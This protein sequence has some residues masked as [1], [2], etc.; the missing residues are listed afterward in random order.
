MLYWLKSGQAKTVEEL[1]TLSGHHRT[2]ISRWLSN[3]RNGGVTELLNIKKSTGRQRKKIQ[4]INI[5]RCA[6][7]VKTRAG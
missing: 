4:S 7:G 3:Y 5:R 6:T 1:A 2:T